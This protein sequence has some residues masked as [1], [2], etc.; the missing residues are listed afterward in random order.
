[1]L[2]LVIVLL[3]WYGDLNISLFIILQIKEYNK[4]KRRIKSSPLSLPLS[5]NVSL[6]YGKNNCFRNIE[7]YLAQ[8]NKIQNLLWYFL[9]RCVRVICSVNLASV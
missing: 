5:Y 4:K 1:M 6:T 2:D 8:Q 9:L 7:H 3:S